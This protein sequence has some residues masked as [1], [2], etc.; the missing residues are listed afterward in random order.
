MLKVPWVDV[1]G[2]ASIMFYHNILQIS[3][4]SEGEVAERGL[5][6]CTKCEFPL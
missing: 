2:L 5:Q 6:R 3:E 4:N 1:R